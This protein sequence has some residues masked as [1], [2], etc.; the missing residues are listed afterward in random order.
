MAN[1]RRQA[2]DTQV[3]VN[4]FERRNNSEALMK[5]LASIDSHDIRCKFKNTQDPINLAFETINESSL[6]SLAKDF[7]KESFMDIVSFISDFCK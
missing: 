2:V 1:A 6:K 5:S 3:T 7:V 4:P